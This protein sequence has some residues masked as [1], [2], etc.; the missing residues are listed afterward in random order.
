EVHPSPR[1]SLPPG[2]KPSSRRLPSVHR[3]HASGSAHR[4]HLVPHRPEHAGEVGGSVPA[5]FTAISR[6][7]NAR[8]TS[9]TSAATPC[10]SATSTTRCSSRPRASATGRTIAVAWSLLHAQ[11]AAPPH[12]IGAGVLCCARRDYLAKPSAS[13]AAAVRKYTSALTCA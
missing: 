10:S 2:R 1:N 4:T 3:Q 6:D 13:A 9:S 7:P 11:T 8:T 5:L 12:R